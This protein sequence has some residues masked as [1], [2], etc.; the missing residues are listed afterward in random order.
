M[1]QSREEDFLRNTSILH[2]LPQNY[3]PWGV[4]SW[5]LQ[6]LV[7]L[8]YRCYIPNL[9]KI[10]SV[11]LEKK[12]LTDNGRRTTHDTRRR[13]PTHSNRSPEWLRWPKNLENLPEI[14]PISRSGIIQ[15]VQLFLQVL[16]FLCP[17]WVAVFHVLSNLFL[18]VSNPVLR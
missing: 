8:P 17:A 10:G 1:P 12:M 18:P 11:V 6:F 14:W 4:G 5:N 15:T 3:L 9:V 7:S 13:T 2:F 16:A